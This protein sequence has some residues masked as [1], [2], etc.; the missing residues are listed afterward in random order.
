MLVTGLGLTNEGEPGDL[1]GAEELIERQEQGM[2]AIR[3]VLSRYGAYVPLFLGDKAVAIFGLPA[4]HEDDPE[5]AVRAALDLQHCTT[6]GLGVASGIHTGMVYLQGMTAGLPAVLPGG[7]AQETV[8]LGSAVDMALRLYAAAGAGETLVTMS[9]QQFTIGAVDY[10]PR[11]VKLP[12]TRTPTTAYSPAG[13]LAITRKVRGIPGLAASLVGR[14]REIADL[15]AAARRMMVDQAGCLIQIAGEPGVGKSRL[16]AELHDRLL[17]DETT[18]VTWLEGRCAELTG[19]TAYGPFREILRGFVRFASDAD[20]DSDEARAQQLVAKLGTLW[21]QAGLPQAQLGEITPFLGNLLS[22]QGKWGDVTIGA[23]AAEET[24]YRTV[25]AIAAFAGALARSKPTVLVLEDLHWADPHSLVVVQQIAARLGAFPLALVCVTRP[26]AHTARALDAAARLC[27]QHMLAIQLAELSPEESRQLVE[28][29]LSLTPLPAT[30][31]LA[32]LTALVLERTEGNPLFVEET[33]RAFIDAGALVRQDG[34]WSVD[35][36][37]LR[38]MAGGTPGHVPEAV[39][40]VLLSRFDSQPPHVRQA[41]QIAAVIGRAVPLVLYSR[42]LPAGTDAAAL[43]PA[44]EEAGFLLA[45]PAH[46]H[47]QLIFRHVLQQAVA[48]QAIGKAT[49][50]ALHGTCGA[51]HCGHLAN[52]GRRACGAACLPLQPQRRSAQSHRIPGQGR[53]KGAAALPQRCGHG[54]LRKGAGA[55]RRAARR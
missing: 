9:T 13:M 7:A 16:V 33:L 20:D 40:S 36:A 41:L 21:Q 26:E 10:T 52:T 35:E 24:H 28:Q 29:L 25:G 6:G 1:V 34:A 55:V 39:Q 43:L 18:D 37:R 51:G 11:Q 32:G 4:S 50:R 42:L 31:D 5:R 22:L 44:L 8:V 49:R 48:Y 53:R 54:C 47:T 27:Q 23:L 15:L 30:P 45:D 19:D 3:G 46:P 14:D 38:L 17:V 2:Q 12:G